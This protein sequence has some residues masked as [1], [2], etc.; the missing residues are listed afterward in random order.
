MPEISLALGYSD[1]RTLAHNLRALKRFVHTCY[2]SGPKL[3]AIPETT[4]VIRGPGLSHGATLTE[5][6]R[7]CRSDY[8]LLAFG[9]SE[10]DPSP[11]LL[12]RMS[13][14]LAGSSAPFVYSAHSIKQP[15][16]NTPQLQPLIDY[17]AGSGRDDFDF[18]DLMLFDLARVR[19]GLKEWGKDLPGNHAG[20]YALRLAG[21]LKGL[22]RRLPDSLYSLQAPPCDPEQEH[23]RY[24]DPAN[25]EYQRQVEEVFKHYSQKA[26]FYLPPRELT[27]DLYQ[28][29]F[30]VECSVVIPVKNR[31]NTIRDALLSALSQEASFAFNLIVVDNHST[32]GTRALLAEQASKD[33]RLIHI[34]PQATNLGIGGCWNEAIYHSLCGRVAGQLDSDDL[35]I[36]KHVLQRV[37]DA[38]YLGQAAALVGAYKLVDENL[39]DLPPGIIDHRE[40]TDENGH[41]NALRINGFGA[42]RAFY[43]PVARKNP[44]PNVSYG[45]DYAVM[46]AITRSYKLVR[47]FE[48]LYLCRRWPG[49]SDSAPSLEKINAWNSYKDGLRTE[50]IAERRKLNASALCTE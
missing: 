27:V 45:E 22:P 14:A 16:Q 43:T 41:N 6:L 30:P 5:L 12:T 18:G 2:V 38:F 33:P 26:G 7:I 37:V 49:N 34:I 40:W 32:D 20:W 44:F 11:D 29:V 47:I 31:V 1:E 42:P 9:H 10:I 4:P 39:T 17:Q 19:A 28:D 25:L 13:A 36:D 24:V 46:L 15:G 50:E 8:L 23:F 3:E 35:Y 48:P 21:C